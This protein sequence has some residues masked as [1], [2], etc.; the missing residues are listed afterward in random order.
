[1]YKQRDT[2]DS[3]EGK[4][5][6]D[7]KKLRSRMSEEKE[8]KKWSEDDEFHLSDEMSETIEKNER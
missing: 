6:N 1:M 5:E 4:W 7:R 3:R 2:K 8:K